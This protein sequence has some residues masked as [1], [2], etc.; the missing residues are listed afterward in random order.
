MCTLLHR[1]W[2]SEKF[3]DIVVAL[4]HYLSSE[5]DITI[6]VCLRSC[7]LFIRYRGRRLSTSVT[8]STSKDRIVISLELHESCRS[9]NYHA[10]CS[11][12]VDDRSLAYQYQ[13][14]AKARILSLSPCPHSLIDKRINALVT[15]NRPPAKI[16]EEIPVRARVRLRKRSLSPSPRARGKEW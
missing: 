10:L 8:R 14:P 9:Q 16:R 1:I 5:R 13:T 7:S 3:W 4:G 15:R 11:R 2:N 12:V 6:Y